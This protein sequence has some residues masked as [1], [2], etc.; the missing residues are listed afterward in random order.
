MSPALML[1]VACGLAFA[2]GACCAFQMMTDAE[3]GDCARQ[4]AAHQRT[5]KAVEHWA[6]RA[7]TAEQRWNDAFMA[8][9]EQK[10]YDRELANWKSSLDPKL[11]AMTPE[12]VERMW[13]GIWHPVKPSPAS[14][15]TIEQLI[16][17]K[18][19]G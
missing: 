17:P 15:A 5:L 16:A 7:L 6:G 4:K 9:Q 18:G 2:G 11:A 10:A 1:I 3:C 14:Y 12:Q 13:Q 19:E 8:D